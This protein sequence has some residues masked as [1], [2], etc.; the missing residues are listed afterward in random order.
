MIRDT[1]GVSV[2]SPIFGLRKEEDRAVLPRELF[3]SRCGR[4]GVDPRNFIPEIIMSKHFVH[5]QPNV[6]VDAP[7]A[8]DINA[9]LIGE[10]VAHER[11]TLVNHGK[12]GS[13]SVPPSVAVGDHFHNGLVFLDFV[14]FADFDI[15]GEVRADG[16]RRVNVDEVDFPREFIAEG[17]EGEF[18]VAPDESVAE[19]VAEESVAFGVVQFSLR[20]ESGA[21]FVDGF[22]QLQGGGQSGKD[23]GQFRVASL[24][25]PDQFGLA[26]GLPVFLLRF[27]GHNKAN[28]TA[29]GWNSGRKFD[30]FFSLWR[31]PR[32]RHRLKSGV[33]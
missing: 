18:V 6:S 30:F 9:S 17:V 22:H 31:C 8:V 16:E 13:D 27:R 32:L 7:V 25:V 11:Q 15:Q 12:V 20:G 3:L 23:V 14:I 10:Q 1:H 28:F 5:H 4:P 19:V 2:E 24:A 26:A 33:K 21:G 29:F